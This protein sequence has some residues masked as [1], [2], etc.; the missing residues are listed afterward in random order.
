MDGY[1]WIF[2]IKWDLG[3]NWGYWIILGLFFLVFGFW[4]GD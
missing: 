4:I 2:L 3:D 1:D